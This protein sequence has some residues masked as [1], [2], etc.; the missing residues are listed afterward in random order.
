MS[1]PSFSAHSEDTN[2]LPPDYCNFLTA[3]ATSSSTTSLPNASLMSPTIPCS[4]PTRVSPSRA[5]TAKSS[6]LGKV[7]LCCC[8][9]LN[10]NHDPNDG[11]VHLTCPW[12]S[13]AYAKVQNWNM[14]GKQPSSLSPIEF[15]GHL[16]VF[17]VLVVSPHFNTMLCTFK[18]VSP[19]FKGMTDS[20]HLFV[21]DLII[22]LHCTKAFWVEGNGVPLFV[23]RGLLQKHCTCGYIRTVCFDPVWQVFSCKLQDGCRS[24]V[25]LESLEGFLFN[26]APGLFH[27][28]LCQL[29]QGMCMFQKPFYEPLIEVCKTKEWLYLLSVQGYGPISH[30][31]NLHWVHLCLALWNNQA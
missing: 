13:Q 19:L 20:Q 14:K 16:E 23:L 12:C 31:S 6:A 9:H 10:L 21:M 30:S 1:S 17:Q 4:S 15:L 27:F 22:S 24:E 3:T 29:E 25:L 5:W 8:C 11:T 18:A 26:S 28:L 7:K 2:D